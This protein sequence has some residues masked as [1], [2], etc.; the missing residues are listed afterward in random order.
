MTQQEKMID[1]LNNLKNTVI[2]LAVEVQKAGTKIN[3]T[4]ELLTILAPIEASI[5]KATLKTLNKGKA[6]PKQS[7]IKPARS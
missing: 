5:Q 1:G 4:V 2:N 6:I 7:T 3:E